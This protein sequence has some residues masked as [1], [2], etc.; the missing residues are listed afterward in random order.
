MNSHAKSGIR[1]KAANYPL[2]GNSASAELSFEPAIEIAGEESDNYCAKFR[3]YP[4]DRVLKLLL[5]SCAD[6]GFRLQLVWN[7]GAVH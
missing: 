3:F 6:R 2:G 4:R 5:W 7:S 1:L